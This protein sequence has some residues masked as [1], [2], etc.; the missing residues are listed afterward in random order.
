MLD[1]LECVIKTIEVGNI[2]FKESNIQPEEYVDI[3]CAK[4]GV[5][6]ASV[7]NVKGV[8]VIV[9]ILPGVDK[10]VYV[11]D[12][13]VEFRITLLEKA[14]VVVLDS[15][16]KG[17]QYTLSFNVLKWLQNKRDAYSKNYR[18]VDNDEKVK[19]LEEL[20]NL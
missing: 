19:L 8:D 13:L 18:L 2:K 17:S 5:V 4:D 9:Y 1:I 7:I 20:R 14:S 11:T 15:D 12:N 10:T 3:R 6:M 16:R